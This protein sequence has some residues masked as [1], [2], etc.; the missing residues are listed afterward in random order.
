MAVTATDAESPRRSQVLGVPVDVC[1]DVF[2]AALALRD[3]GG[4]QIVTLN[5][6]MTMA[7]RAD[8]ELGRAIAAAGLVI[9]DGAGVVWA[10]GRRGL[11]LRRSPGI[12]LARCLLEH[13][14]A[15]R[16]R[17]ALVGAS[18]AVMERLQSRLRDELPA[19][20]PVFS[21]HGYQSAETWPALEA[22]LLASRPD[23]VLVALG[24]PRQETWI[25]A[26]PGR[27][28]GLWMGVGG[29]FDVWAGV[30]KRAPGWM[31]A[32]HIE[33][34]YR[35]VQEPRRWRRMLALPAFAW[36]VLKSG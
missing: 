13:G 22:R 14:A 31:G 16:W 9:P 4:G 26:L 29:S 23:L 15:Q 6:E 5:A 24:V 33:W 28:G 11:R 17:V 8:P 19:L 32:L 34:L 1:P 10:L 18:P 30:K 2:A 3:R 21:A 36:A 20:E 12:E 25:A 27:Q 7:A 35:L